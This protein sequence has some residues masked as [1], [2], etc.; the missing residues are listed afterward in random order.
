MRL[1][2]FRLLPMLFAAL[3]LPLQAVAAVTMPFCT[4]GHQAPVAA[5]SA[6]GGAHAEHCHDTLPETPLPLH[7]GSACDQCGFC[8]LACA[9]MA[10]GIVAVTGPL[11]A[12]DRYQRLG[13]LFPP[14]HVPALLQPPPRGI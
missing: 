14:D 10:P 7:D 3:W 2:W 5:Q 1:P 4:H 13:T 6:D 8:H 11:L 9:A 12:A